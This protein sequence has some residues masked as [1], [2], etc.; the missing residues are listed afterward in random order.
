LSGKVFISQ[1]IVSQ[2][3]RS[4]AMPV[5]GVIS[6]RDA[7]RV[8]VP[9]A[10]LLVAISVLASCRL[11]LPGRSARRPDDAIEFNSH[12][13]KVY[14]ADLSWHEAR[15][16]CLQAGGYMAC[17][18]TAEEQAF[19][20]GLAD[21]R[22]LSLGGTDEADEGKWVW[23]NGSEFKYECWMSGQPNN[24]GGDEHYLATYD[25]GEWVDVAARGD[26]FWMPTGYICEWDR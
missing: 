1:I 22:Y 5:R 2:K 23:C 3:G 9:A 21:G 11:P 13:Y 4:G 19:I 24:Y 18:E 14:E 12:W 10:A 7:V 15:D 25:G 6:W 20:A 8:A 26:G 16:L 17:I